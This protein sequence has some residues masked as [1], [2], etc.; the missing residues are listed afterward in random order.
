VPAAYG[1]HPE[2]YTE[3]LERKVEDAMC[4]SHRSRSRLNFACSPVSENYWCS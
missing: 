1:R 4:S 3:A 2:Y